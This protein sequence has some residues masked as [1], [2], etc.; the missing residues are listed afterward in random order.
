MDWILL[1]AITTFVLLLAFLWWTQ[2]S[3]K[4]H[5]ES[6]GGNV[7]GIGGE[8]DPLSGT[9]SGMRDPE[10]MRRAMNSAQQPGYILQRWR[11]HSGKR[12]V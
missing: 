12:A 5:R 6:G 10:V 9:T 11:D 3:L 7:S 1:L 8:S 4:R 2:A